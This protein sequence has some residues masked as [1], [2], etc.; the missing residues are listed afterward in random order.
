MVSQQVQVSREWWKKLDW[1]TITYQY[2]QPAGTR[3]DTGQ[4]K[5]SSNGLD[6]AQDGDALRGKEMLKGK[7]KKEEANRGDG[8]EQKALDRRQMETKLLNA[9]RCTGFAIRVE[10][11]RVELSRVEPSLV[12]SRLGLL[13]QVFVDANGSKEKKQH[14]TVACTYLLATVFWGF[15]EGPLWYR[16]TSCRR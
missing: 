6:L 1:M 12:S 2:V 16:A 5:R 7:K 4:R 10:S 15:W 14:G 8:A 3:E 11:S 9:R 13:L